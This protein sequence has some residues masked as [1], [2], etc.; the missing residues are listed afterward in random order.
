MMNTQNAATLIEARRTIA[1]FEQASG[2]STTEM[3]VCD[4]GDARLKKI[5]CF[6]LMDWH[7]AV[8]QVEVLKHLD[9]VVPTIQSSAYTGGVHYFTFRYKDQTSKELVNAAEPELLLVA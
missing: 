2:L 5:D 8:E 1:E 7:Y 4:E 6:D 3:L 9:A